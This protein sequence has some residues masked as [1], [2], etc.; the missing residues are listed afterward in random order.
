M[1]PEGPSSELIETPLHF[2]YFDLFKDTNT[3]N[4]QRGTQKGNTAKGLGIHKSS[5]YLGENGWSVVAGELQERS[6]GEEE[7]HETLRSGMWHMKCSDMEEVGIAL[8]W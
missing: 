3:L 5:E 6:E 2:Q 1:F 7:E 8:T 4:A